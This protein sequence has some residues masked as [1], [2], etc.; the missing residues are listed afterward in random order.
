MM[1][2]A[3]LDRIHGFTDQDD[4]GTAIFRSYPPLDEELEVLDPHRVPV[5][6]QI[7]DEHIVALGIVAGL[8][9]GS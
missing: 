9:G 1:L 3:H 4:V 8:L 7:H 5:I 6:V 2:A